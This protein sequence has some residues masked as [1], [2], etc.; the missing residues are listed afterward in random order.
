MSDSK[1]VDLTGDDDDEAQVPAAKKLK[2]MSVQDQLAERVRSLQAKEKEKQQGFGAAP[3]QYPTPPP[4]A[5][6]FQRSSA[7]ASAAAGGS[8][9]QSLTSLLEAECGVTILRSLPTPILILRTGLRCG[10]YLFD[11]ACALDVDLQTTA[12]GA[13]QQTKGSMRKCGAAQNSGAGEAAANGKNCDD[14][15]ILC[16]DSN[17]RNED[18]K[19]LVL[20]QASLADWHDR[21]V[22]PLLR[23]A[24]AQLGDGGG[25]DFLLN[26]RPAD[27]SPSSERT[28]ETRIL[29]YECP[30][31]PAQGVRAAHPVFHRHFDH[32]FYG[33][34][35]LASFGASADFFVRVSR[36]DE[37]VVCLEHG[38]V[39]VF[40]AARES[41]VLHGVDA[42]HRPAAAAANPG[43]ANLGRFLQ[44]AS[45]Q[46]PLRRMIAQPA[47]RVSLQYRVKWPT[48]LLRIQLAW[49]ARNLF[50]FEE[51]KWQS[52]SSL[53]GLNTSSGG[54]RLQQL[55]QLVDHVAAPCYGGGGGPGASS[56]APIRLLLEAVEDICC[57][58]GNETKYL[59]EEILRWNV[60]GPRPQFACAWHIDK[61]CSDAAWN[62]KIRVDLPL[63]AAARSA[64]PG[65][66]CLC[67]GGGGVKAKLVAVKK[68]GPNKDRLFWTCAKPQ[69]QGCKY[70]EWADAQGATSSAT[71]PAFISLP[72]ARPTAA[73]G[74]G[75]GAGAG[76]A[77]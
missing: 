26:H 25:V 37:R 41:D 7:A 72:M 70:F 40:D 10:D 34:T 12:A 13:L 58:P 2:S 30:R 42:I 75:A 69:G 4:L 63:T 52:V 24:A 16:A 77:K 6:V 27:F 68:D 76:W 23:F 11:L 38:D 32:S 66:S 46:S 65:K 5:S 18:P 67:G 74:E 56:S 57:A 14:T 54:S 36:G 9:A 59:A 33:L 44:Q 8:P 64:G 50:A 51:Q 55:Q 3:A 47:V 1:V 15:Y 49:A 29:K 45:H 73:A 17:P 43:A 31:G 20:S 35:V 22:E 48:R 61:D 53:L 28:G 62:S 71:A 39:L 60:G 21:A 19:K